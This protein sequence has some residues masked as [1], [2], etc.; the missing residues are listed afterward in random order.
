ME[1]GSYLTM[2]CC[3]WFLE[4]MIFLVEFGCRGMMTWNISLLDIIRSYHVPVVT[5]ISWVVANNIVVLDLKYRIAKR[6]YMFLLERHNQQTHKICI[7]CDVLLRNTHLTFDFSMSYLVVRIF[8]LR[9]RRLQ[10]VL[11]SFIQVTPFWG[12]M[13][14]KSSFLIWWRYGG[15]T[16]LGNGYY[17]EAL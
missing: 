3:R 16:W 14:Q 7:I 8:W 1:G 9:D 13:F 6:A 10:N 17:H 5:D 4:A 2:P 15:I 12:N 11:G